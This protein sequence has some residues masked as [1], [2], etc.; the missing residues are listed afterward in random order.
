MYSFIVSFFIY[1]YFI[2]KFKIVFFDQL[3][4]LKDAWI[5]LFFS[6]S[7]ITYLG[8]GK[9]R[10]LICH[11]FILHPFSNCL[12][13]LNSPTHFVTCT[14]HFISLLKNTFS[15]IFNSSRSFEGWSFFI[16]VFQTVIFSKYNR[17]IPERNIN[18]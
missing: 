13:H 12:V 10:K 5:M 7:F 1:F 15:H 8:W 9:F 11:S 18:H 17:K 2:R 3:H 14:N 4:I 16:T 6:E